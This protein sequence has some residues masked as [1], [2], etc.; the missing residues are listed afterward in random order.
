MSIS[1]EIRDAIRAAR[2]AA[3]TRPDDPFKKVL[4]EVAV[5]L[6]D[7]SVEARFTSGQGGRWTLWLSPV[8]RPG[9]PSAMLTVV[10]GPSGA[11]VLLQPKRSA[12]K[13]EELAEILK[14]F[15]TTPNFLESM[16][17]IAELANQPVEGFLRV[18]PRTVSRDDL[19]LEVTPDQQRSIAGSVG[20]D[21]TLS[22]RISDFPGAGTFKPE[23]GYR[24]L[25]AAGF[26]VT[27]AKDGVSQHDKGELRLIGRVGLTV[28][29]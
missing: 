16:A 10:I 19:M 27:L 17:A 1:Q 21:I 20:S 15:V 3:E 6:T 14:G 8:H 7:E 24:V 12:A 13:P 25:E 22:L 29:S 9:R 23:A 11:E 2:T 28:P 26:S 18:A 5:G 4:D